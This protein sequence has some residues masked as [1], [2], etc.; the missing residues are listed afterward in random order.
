LPVLCYFCDL[1]H[2]KHKLFLNP[3]ILRFQTC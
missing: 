1:L 2:K 3:E